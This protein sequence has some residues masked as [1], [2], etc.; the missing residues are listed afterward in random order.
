MNYVNHITGKGSETVR[1]PFFR[2]SD[3]LRNAS[4][5]L[6]RLLYKLRLTFGFLSARI[7][8]TDTALTACERGLCDDASSISRATGYFN[9]N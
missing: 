9:V 2:L 4:L 3:S 6:V 5:A 8:E 7:I 1:Q